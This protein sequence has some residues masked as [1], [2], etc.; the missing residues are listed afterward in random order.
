M[1][2]ESDVFIHENKDE[3]YKFKRIELLITIHRRLSL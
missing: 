1:W 2:Q 3:I